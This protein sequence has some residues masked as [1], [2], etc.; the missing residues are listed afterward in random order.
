M[1]EAFTDDNRNRPEWCALVV[2]AGVGRRFGGTRKAGLE[3]A[4][5]PLAV[6]SMRTLAGCAGFVS[7]VVVVHGE[8]VDVANSS[9]V[10]RVPG[11]WRVA[12]GGNSRSESVRAGLEATLEEAEL[13][14]IHDAARPLVARTDVERVL[15]E[16]S[17]VGAALLASPVVETIKRAES[18]V[19][20]ETV[21]RSSLWKA[22]TPQVFRQEWIREAHERFPDGDTDDAALLERLG[23]PVALVQS[24]HPNLKVT[25]AADLRLAQGFLAEG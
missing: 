4:G 12:V 11:D 10:A 13:V 23:C 25:H 18:G 19:V 21:D 5:E 7:G 24:E 9:W 8:D 1:S 6:H 14:A 3:L 16:A 20:R 17:R 15:A 2:A 22:E